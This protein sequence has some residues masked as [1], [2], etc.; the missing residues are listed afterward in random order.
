VDEQRFARAS[1]PDSQLYGILRPRQRDGLRL[2]AVSADAALLFLTL[3][4]PGQLPAYIRSSLGDSCEA[5]IAKFVG[6]GVLELNVG[7]GFVWGPSGLDALLD[8]SNVGMGQG[9]FDALSAAAIQFA[10][11]LASTDVLE[12]ATRLYTYNR[13]PASPRWRNQL[14]SPNDVERFL[15]IGRSCRLGFSLRGDWYCWVSSHI[16]DDATSC[17]YK[18]YVSP[19]PSALRETVAIIT[20]VADTARANAQAHL[21]V[22]N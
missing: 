7:G 13:M 14:G 1:M 22:A 9:Q 18:L 19:L 2:M 8:G 4:E 16:A 6:D 3:R 15:G 11:S 17:A 5:T 20:A 12:L 10:S 21:S